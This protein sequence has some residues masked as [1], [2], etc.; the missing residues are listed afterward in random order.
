MTDERLVFV[1][2][3]TTGLNPRSDL[4]LE[5][6]M[7]I[8]DLDFNEL[9]TYSVPVRYG[10]VVVQLRKSW[11]DAKVVEMHERSGLWQRCIDGWD[12][13]DLQQVRDDITTLVRAYCP[14]PKETRLAGNSV[15]FDKGFLDFHV[16][17]L[18]ELVSYRIVDVSTLSFFAN[19]WHGIPL[20][21]KQYK[22]EAVADIRES[23]AEMK[24]IIE[25]EK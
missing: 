6:G 18:A 14:N 23:I 1:D 19:K 22:H 3:E 15:H 8:T 24:Y 25:K 5:V 20:M 10:P 16:P 2:L 13:R 11:S 7:V 4:I 17:T 21:E 12:S 9:A